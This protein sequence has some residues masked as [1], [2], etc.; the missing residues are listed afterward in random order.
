[1]SVSTWPAFMLLTSSGKPMESSVIGSM[2]SVVP[3]APSDS[4]M[5][6]TSATTSAGWPSPHTNTDEPFA[7]FKSFTS[8]SKISFSC[9]P[10]KFF[11]AGHVAKRSMADFNVE[12]PVMPSACAIMAMNTGISPRRTVN[13]LSAAIPETLTPASTTYILFCVCLLGS[14]ARTR[15]PSAQARVLRSENGLAEN[16]SQSRATMTVAFSSCG[17]ARVGCPNAMREPSL[18]AVPKMGFH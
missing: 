6:A 5:A 10:N 13:R 12:S 8:C 1:M 15:R 4:L 9:S 3:L 16:G 18:C 17:C 2:F 11:D 7:P 14:S